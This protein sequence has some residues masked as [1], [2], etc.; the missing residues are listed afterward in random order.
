MSSTDFS[1]YLFYVYIFTMSVLWAELPEIKIWFVGWL[2]TQVVWMS[3]L[4]FH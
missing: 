4:G 1:L 2:I 3:L